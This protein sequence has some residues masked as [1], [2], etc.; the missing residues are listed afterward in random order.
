MDGFS[1]NFVKW[2]NLTEETVSC[3]VI[4]LYVYVCWLD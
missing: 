4:Q 3:G 1:E 2:Y